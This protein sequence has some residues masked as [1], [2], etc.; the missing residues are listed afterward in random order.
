MAGKKAGWAAALG[1]LVGL[2]APGAAS[3]GP[4]LGEWGLWYHPHDCP[5]GS[6]SPWHYWFRGYYRIRAFCNPSYLDQYPP[7]PCPPVEP[8]FEVKRYP[9]PPIPPAPHTPYADPVGY[10]GLGISPQQDEELSIR[11]GTGGGPTSPSPA[12]MPGASRY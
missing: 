7:G 3:A 5:R 6:Y 11:Q 4:Y 8:S 12:Q 9:C 10:Y 1:L 2:L